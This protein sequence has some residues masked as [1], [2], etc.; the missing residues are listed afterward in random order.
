[1]PASPLP[2]ASTLPASPPPASAAA[3]A[4]AA[5]GAS[6]LSLSPDAPG[7]SAG[8]GARPSPVRYGVR[9]TARI[10]RILGKKRGG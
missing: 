7:P 8:W 3:A 2:Q 4:E 1:M 5:A 10:E 6:V 9:E